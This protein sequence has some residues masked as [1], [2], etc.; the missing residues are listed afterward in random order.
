MKIIT[1][2]HVK[3]KSQVLCLGMNFFL[4]FLRLKEKLS[5]FPLYICV[6][7]SLF[8]IHL[9]LPLFT[10]GLAFWSLIIETDGES[11]TM[12]DFDIKRDINSYYVCMKCMKYW[13][14]TGECLRWVCGTFFMKI[15]FRNG[16]Y[17]VHDE[18]LLKC[19][20][21]VVFVVICLKNI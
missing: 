4:S 15:F 21:I 14:V 12:N 17:F 18:I 2:G 5:R 11:L 9:D 3:I 19:V 10:V 16:L 20:K 7:L 13:F 1:R 8:Y 6:I